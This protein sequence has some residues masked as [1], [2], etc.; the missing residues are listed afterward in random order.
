MNCIFLVTNSTIKIKKNTWRHCFAAIRKNARKLEL[1]LPANSISILKKGKK[2]TSF[3]V[4]CILNGTHVFPN[5][6][7][8]KVIRLKTTDFEINFEINHEIRLD[9]LQ[10]K[11]VFN[12]SDLSSCMA[13]VEMSV[14]KRRLLICQ[15]CLCPSQLLISFC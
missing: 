11:C 15:I 1:H 13:A 14:E 8:V 5:C 2:I 6:E 10:R 3:R 7:D 12:A 9:V 4:C